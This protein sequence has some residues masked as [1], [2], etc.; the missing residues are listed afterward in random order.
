MDSIKKGGKRFRVDSP[1]KKGKHLFLPVRCRRESGRR[2]EKRGSG[3]TLFFLG[4]GVPPAAGEISKRK[5]KK[6]GYFYS[7]SIQG[8]N[9]RYTTKNALSVITKGQGRKT[10]LANSSS[11]DQLEK[12]EVV[13]ETI[14]ESD[15]GGRRS[16]SPRGEME[17]GRS[18][19]SPP[20]ASSAGSGSGSNGSEERKGPWRRSGSLRKR[21]CPFAEVAGEGKRAYSVW[22]EEVRI[23]PGCPRRKGERVSWSLEPSR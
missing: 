20:I 6:P 19:R 10:R 7:L 21:G 14:L 3:S 17:M 13:P 15:R 8:S 16:I 11:L 18:G 9:A 1:R 4:K 23:V 5:G 22:L 12:G 2:R